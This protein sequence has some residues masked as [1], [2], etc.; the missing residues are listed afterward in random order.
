MTVTT[1][2]RPTPYR[3]LLIV[4]AI[5]VALG[6]GLYLSGSWRT[7]QV[8]RETVSQPLGAA[9]SADAATTLIRFSM[10]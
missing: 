3:P 10:V 6:A 5:V 8:V 7:A 4:A 1:L 2:N 9:R